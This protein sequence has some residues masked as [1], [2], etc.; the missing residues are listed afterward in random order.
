MEESASSGRSG[1]CATSG[2]AWDLSAALTS[3]LRGTRAPTCDA[4]TG[5]RGEQLG[6]AEQT[7]SSMVG[8]LIASDCSH[9]LRCGRRVWGEQS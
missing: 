9:P 1:I 6:A 7:G 2:S 8:G 5:Q 3:T 4:V